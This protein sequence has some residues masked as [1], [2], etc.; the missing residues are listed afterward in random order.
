M[1]KQP[2]CLPMSAITCLASEGRITL[3]IP[4]FSINLSGKP[5]PV[6]PHIPDD[7]MSRLNGNTPAP[8][9]FSYLSRKGWKAN[10]TAI[11]AAF[12]VGV[13]RRD[14]TG[15]WT[16]AKSEAAWDNHA[17]EHFANVDASVQKAVASLQKKIATLQSFKS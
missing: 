12:V 1:A 15:G 10:R 14:P 5:L 8:N 9:G 6:E 16:Q 11:I 7:W 3:Q 2:L 4:Q 17:K 13:Q